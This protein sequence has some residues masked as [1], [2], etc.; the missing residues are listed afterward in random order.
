MILN[1]QSSVIPVRKLARHLHNVDNEFG[2]SM[3][4]R[5]IDCLKGIDNEAD[6]LE[7]NREFL[8]CNSKCHIHNCI[9]TR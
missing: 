2:G 3:A 9:P 6:Y 8:A 1:S 7:R 5:A 4:S